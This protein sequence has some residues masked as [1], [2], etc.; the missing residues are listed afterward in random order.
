MAYGCSQATGQIG[1]AAASLHTTAT[2]DLS[3]IRDLCYSL[4]QPQILNPLNEARDR[5][6]ILMD[7]SRVLNP[8]SHNGK[9]SHVIKQK[10]L[11]FVIDTK[12]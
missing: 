2:L 8:L 10:L 3:H 4:R 1:A 6:Y 12:H 9:S 7:T 11:Y 5:T